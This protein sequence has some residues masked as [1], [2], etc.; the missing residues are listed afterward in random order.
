MEPTK[1]LIDALWRDKVEQARRS[2]PEE[3]LR[4]G[5]ELYDEVIERMIAGIR[6]QFPQASDEH[7]REELLRRLEINERLE[8]RPW[9]ATGS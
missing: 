1:E 2:A 9:R 4:A 5:G 3:K 8:N 6:M 7:V